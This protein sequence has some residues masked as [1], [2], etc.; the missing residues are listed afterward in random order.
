M[1]NSNQGSQFNAQEF[2]KTVLDAGFQLSMDGKGA[3]RDNV[4][5]ERV[6]YGT[7]YEWINLGPNR[8][9][10]KLAKT[11]GDSSKGTT[12]KGLIRA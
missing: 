8:Q 12:Q 6:W 2:S 3:W 9:S 4:L 5:I 11:L 1:V 10:V 7:K